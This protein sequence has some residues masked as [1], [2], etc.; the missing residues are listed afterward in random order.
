MS[1]L[2]VHSRI[3]S[4]SLSSS[5]FQK[6]RGWVKAM[7]E[8]AF[9]TKT[10]EKNTMRLFLSRI[11][12]RVDFFSSGKK[13]FT[14]SPQ[15]KANGINFQWI[16]RFAY[17]IKSARGK[18]NDERWKIIKAFKNRWKVSN[19]KT[20]LFPKPVPSQEGKEITHFV[21]FSCE[22]RQQSRLCSFLCSG[23]C[24]WCLVKLKDK[25]KTRRRKM[26]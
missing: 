4:Q 13:F 24:W 11:F 2:A 15:W 12:S 21:S 17:L 3:A 14:Q 23:C 1:R 25:K 19:L 8:H 10:L 9:L 26:I 22:T 16:K 20:I 6:H 5:P 18:F 7:M